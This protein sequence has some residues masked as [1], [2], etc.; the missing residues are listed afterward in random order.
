MN[1]INDRLD[2]ES[3]KRQ[4]LEEGVELLKDKCGLG[5]SHHAFPNSDKNSIDE[6]RERIAKLE[7]EV[8]SPLKDVSRDESFKNDKDELNR[9]SDSIKM[10]FKSEK[11]FLRNFT[12]NMTEI[13][14]RGL[15]SM[16]QK[17]EILDENTNVSVEEIR[18]DLN[19]KLDNVAQDIEYARYDIES[20]DLKINFIEDKVGPN[21]DL[22]EEL[23]KT[24][25]DWKDKVHR[26]EE[27]DI[28]NGTAKKETLGSSIYSL[29][30]NRGFRL[31]QNAKVYKCENN[32]FFALL[33]NKYKLVDESSNEPV[34][35]VYDPMS[36]APQNLVGLAIS[37]DKI[38]IEWDS[39]VHPNWVMGYTIFYTT[40]ASHLLGLWEKKNSYKG[41][42]M[43]TLH[44]LVPNSTYTIRV[45]ANGETI[46]D[47]LSESTNVMTRKGVFMQPT[48][49]RAKALTPNSLLISWDW[50]A[51]I[52]AAQVL[53]YKLF[54][55]DLSS[56]KHNS[57]VIN[58]PTN[59]Y[60][61]EDLTPGTIY[62]IQMSATNSHGEGAKTNII[63]AR[64]PE[65]I[66]K[67]PKRVYATA[68]SSTTILVKWL[69]PSFPGRRSHGIIRGYNVYCVEIGEK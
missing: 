60:E 56:H 15:L 69:S 46:R 64:T 3:R 22:L 39:P 4:A 6:L 44:G 67:E 65:F 57:L 2:Q 50:P 31:N 61:L 13:Y 24:K 54:Y 12:K 33:D 30:C 7:K 34:A 8:E 58:P 40:E 1:E 48:N 20:L 26:N 17:L 62:R 35:C 68:I 52:N 55:Y 23:Q 45:M 63:K 27:S 14:K 49:L 43:A 66:P 32:H 59:T 53:S 21:S 47:T 29:S 9:L 41:R 11:T 10:A 38:Y 36:A 28:A 5:D 16:N 18:I 19:M 37:Q 42:R 25:I 51:K